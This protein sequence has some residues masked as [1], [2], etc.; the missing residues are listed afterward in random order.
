MCPR[1][2]K[3]N[4]VYVKALTPEQRRKLLFLARFAITLQKEHKRRS[5]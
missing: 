1:F 3:G 5:P 2:F 4:I